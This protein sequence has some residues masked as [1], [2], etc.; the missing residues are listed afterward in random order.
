LALEPAEDGEPKLATLTE[1]P[2][3]LVRCVGH[4]DA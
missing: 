3:T 4:S 2:Q 1:Q